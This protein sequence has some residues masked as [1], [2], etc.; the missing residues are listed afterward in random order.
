MREFGEKYNGDMQAA[1]KGIQ[2][3]RMGGADAVAEID[4]TTRKRKWVASQ[5]AEAAADP[6][7][8]SPTKLFPTITSK[9]G[10]ARAP[11]RHENML[12]MNGSPIANPYGL[13]MEWFAEGGDHDDDGEQETIREDGKRK[14]ANSIIVRRDPSFSLQAA[15]FPNGKGLHSRAKSQ[16]NLLSSQSATSSQHPQPKH[17]PK[18][19]QAPPRLGNWGFGTALITIP[20]KDGHLL[21]F[22]PLQTSPGAFDALEGISD[23]AKKHAK[24]DMGRLVQG[25]LSK[26]KI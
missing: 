1:L 24:E 3:E 13:G 4:K 10:T 23:S 7:P 9:T 15:P 16:S 18:T 8:V 25:A 20:T 26:W 22:D 5:E 14:R 6:R 12:S 19:P 11:K 2:K 21:E 17:H